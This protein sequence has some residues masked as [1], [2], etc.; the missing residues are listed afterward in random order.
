MKTCYEDKCPRKLICLLE[1][2]SV[3]CERVE[4]MNLNLNSGKQFMLYY[5]STRNWY[6]TCRILWILL[7]V[8][9]VAT[10]NFIYGFLYLLLESARK[11]V[12]SKWDRESPSWNPLL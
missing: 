5:Y 10:V 7:V 3:V 12:V 6:N 8:S 11:K 9:E 1:Y 4:K 2:N